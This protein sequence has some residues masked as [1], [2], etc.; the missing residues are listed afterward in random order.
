MS[1]R[2]RVKT[3]QVT[4]EGKDYE[5]DLSKKKL[6]EQEIRDHVPQYWKDAAE[7]GKRAISVP[8]PG[9]DHYT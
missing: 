9:S 5:S 6:S 2:H 8:I 7:A 4:K 1:K 3:A